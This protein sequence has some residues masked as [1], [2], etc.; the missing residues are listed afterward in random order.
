MAKI[1]TIEELNAIIIPIE[2]NMESKKYISS[3]P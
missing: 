3:V 2:K 1:Y